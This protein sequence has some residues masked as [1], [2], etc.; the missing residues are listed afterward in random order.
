MG[1]EES[2]DEGVSACD[3]DEVGVRAGSG[4]VSRQF[5]RA[6]GQERRASRFKGRVRWRRR[7]ASEVST[8][9]V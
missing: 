7:G 5:I 1:E 6:Y 4:R 8:D 2:E 9:P 3:E